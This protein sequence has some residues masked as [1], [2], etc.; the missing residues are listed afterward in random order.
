MKRSLFFVAVL[1]MIS[2]FLAAPM[3][4]SACGI[5]YC[6]PPMEGSAE[7]QAFENITVEY[8]QSAG[9][10]NINQI[11]FKNETTNSYEVNGDVYG[12]IHTE[13]DTLFFVGLKGDFTATSSN[14]NTVSCLNA[15][16]N[17]MNGEVAMAS[18]AGASA[19]SVDLAGAASSA[20][21]SGLVT[22]TQILPFAGG[23]VGIQ[24]VTIGG[25]TNVTAN[26]GK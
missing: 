24:A 12:S 6:P 9:T 21:N 19:A 17:T 7:A 10:Q 18:N 20:G 22:Q 2:L 11:T 15:K 13:S 23:G 3:P 26:A 8:G 4:S 5:F 14:S 16:L 1:A 25:Y